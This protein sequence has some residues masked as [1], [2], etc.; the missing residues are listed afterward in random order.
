[1]NDRL[2]E[3]FY[4]TRIT[5]YEALHV[6][7]NHPVPV[8]QQILYERGFPLSPVI[9]L[10]E[11]NY[12]QHIGD[13]IILRT[14]MIDGTKEYVMYKTTM[15]KR[16]LSLIYADHITYWSELA[17]IGLKWS[18]MPFKEWQA[19]QLKKDLEE[20]KRLNLE[21]IQR[22]V[23]PPVM[24]A[25]DQQ[26]AERNFKVGQKNFQMGKDSVHLKTWMF[27]AFVLGIVVGHFMGV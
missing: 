21:L 1:M 26:T 24:F 19:S 3:D 6:E 18:D 2:K 20:S 9:P 12:S 10:N 11:D 8:T 5:P 13:Y 22:T 17:R 27:V 4:Y 16:A 25:T 14:E 23:N 15:N 7:R